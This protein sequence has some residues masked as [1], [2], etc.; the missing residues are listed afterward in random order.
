[1]FMTRE[2]IS[3]DKSFDA[4]TEAILERD[5]ARTTDLF[6][7]M[8]RRQGRSVGEALSVVTA[9]EAP[10]VQVPSHINVRDGQIALVNNDHTLLGLRT[11]VSLMSF[12]PEAYRLLPLLQSV[13]YIP[14][15]LD[16]W[17]QLL[18]K[19][20]GRYA[21]MKGY[22][23]PPPDY[24]PVVWQQ[25]QQP[26]IRDGS[27]EERLHEHMVATVSGDVQRAYGLFLGLAADAHVRPRLRD[28][29][30]FLGV[31][32][33]Q[34]TIIGRKARNTGHKSI[35]ARA[36]TDLAD[37]IGWD[38]AHGVFYTGVPDM[39]IGPLYYSLYDAACVTMTDAFPDDAGK[40]LK[41]TNQTPLT[42]QEV[43]EM[44][45][46]LMEADAQTI[47]D[48]I[49][50]HLRSGKSIK[51]LG[52]T[53]QIGA[54]ELIL[55]TTVPRRFTDGQHPFD[56]CNTVNDW[57]RTSDNPYQP[58]ALYLMA[59]FVNDSA[60][61]NTLFTPVLEQEIAAFDF[62]DRT[63]QAL[64]TELDEA[65]V[66]LD[67]PRTTALAHTYLQSGADRHAYQATVA[68]TACK[69]QD[70]PHNQ[71][72][73]HSTFE[74]YHHNSTHLR[75]RLLLA[76]ARQLAGWVK[77]PGERECYARFMKEWINN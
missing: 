6:F 52:D 47:H 73:T 51:S 18:A 42:P 65:I 57:F 60:R 21:M 62:S 20:P 67:I 71:K 63:P 72:I 23:V 8:V 38:R 41:Q 26:I 49:T 55:R 32:D 45:Q 56:Y 3:Q 50:T 30:R 54:A 58:R 68:V 2:Q 37:F 74:E 27:I 44:V 46:L 13:W 70:D 25:E 29:L 11:A 33:L 12:V 77:M 40:H 39:A 22:D 19:Y 53:I 43:E 31:I 48:L 75:D 17:N 5:Q 28:Q 10:F 4:L 1:M 7:R 64:L 66:A 59:N 15:G 35:R 16:I 76:T 14:A 9:A 24:G 36:I 69:F 61:A 34:D